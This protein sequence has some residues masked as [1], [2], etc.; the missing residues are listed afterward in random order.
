M[1]ASLPMAALFALATLAVPLGAEAQT[2]GDRVP[3]SVHV[4]RDVSIV[5]DEGRKIEG[6]V[7]GVSEHSIR[8]AMK[9]ASTDIAMDRV[10]RIEHPDT[11]K[12][13]ALIGLGLGLTFGTISVLDTRGLDNRAAFAAV[14]IVG[15]TLIWTALGT[16]VDAAC[17]NRQTLYQRSG[18]PRASVRP[19]VAPGVRAAAL[20][21]SW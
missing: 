15:N 3:D 2:A 9:R 16:A 19:L 6:R 5:D 20:A 21:L 8:V 18:R 7:E 11:L 4:G 13:G 17:N 10:V 12:N 1:T 14:S